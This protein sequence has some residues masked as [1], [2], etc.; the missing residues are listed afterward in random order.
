MLLGMVAA[1]MDITF[2]PEMAVEP[3]K[4]CKFIPIED[5]HALWL[6]GSQTFLLGHQSCTTI[7]TRFITQ[8]F[9]S[10]NLRVFLLKFKHNCRH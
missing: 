10:F 3:R 2:V 8:T 5:E 4:G 9:C 6:E 7:H 1:G